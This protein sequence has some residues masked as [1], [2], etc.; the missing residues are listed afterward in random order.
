MFSWDVLP[1]W[2]CRLSCLH[3]LLILRYNLAVFSSFATGF[4]QPSVT[5][6]PARILDFWRPPCQHHDRKN[7]I[8]PKTRS[9]K[10]HI[11]E[12]KIRWKSL[13][14]T[15]Q[16]NSRQRQN[17]VMM[18][19]QSVN[20]GKSCPDSA[21]VLPPT[22]NPIRF[23]VDPDK[24]AE[25]GMFVALMNERQFYSTFSKWIMNEFH[26]DFEHV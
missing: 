20:V 10:N 9:Q 25:P 3:W 6:G 21:H 24:G 22:I 8:R 5:Q 7:T 12:K 15:P 2:P 17:E 19:T 23:S 11:K 18:A 14:P 4:S 13:F 1:V 26:W 16:Q